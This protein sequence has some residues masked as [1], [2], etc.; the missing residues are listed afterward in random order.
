LLPSKERKHPKGWT[1]NNCGRIQEIIEVIGLVAIEHEGAPDNWDRIQEI[2][3]R[4]GGV[5]CPPFR[6][7]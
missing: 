7:L 5:R 6:A 2:I 1:P 3:E 4:R